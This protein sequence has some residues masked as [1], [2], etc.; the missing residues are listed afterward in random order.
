MQSRSIDRV[1]ET[2]VEHG[3]VPGGVA[4]AA[5]RGGVVYEGAFGRRALPDGEAMTEDSVFWI[6]SMTKRRFSELAGEAA[7]NQEYASALQE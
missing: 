5:D 6:A 7:C 2:A 4:M 3:D 1:Y